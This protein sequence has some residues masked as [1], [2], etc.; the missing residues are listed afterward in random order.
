M[1]NIAKTIGLF[2]GCALLTGCGSAAGGLNNYPTGAD[3][4]QRIEDQADE[5]EPEIAWPATMEEEIGDVSGERYNPL[6]E[7]PFINA[8]EENQS[9]FSMDSWS[10]SYSNLR[11]YINRGEKING[12]I[13]KT[14]ELINYFDY[15]YPRPTG[16]ED[17]ASTI[18]VADAPWNKDHKL[19]AMAVTTKEAEIDPEQGNNY[20][21]LIDIS[22]SMDTKD[23]LPLVKQSLGL[24]LD[25]LHPTDRVSVVTYAGGVSKVL[26]GQTADNKNYI[27]N[28]INSLTAGGGTY[29]E[30]GIEMAYEVAKKWFI[31]DGNNR[32]I[33]ATDG[34]FNIG[35]SGKD[36]LKKLI[37][38]KRQSGIYLTCLGYGM[39]NYNDIT[40]ETLAKYGN[41]G[42]YYINNLLEA[43]KV[44]VKDLNKTLFA[45]AKDAKCE[46]TFDK[47]TVQSY[48]LIGYE[49]KAISQQDFYDETKD[50]GEIG[51]GHTSV[52]CYELIL[53]DGADLTGGLCNLNIHYKDPKTDESKAYVCSFSYLEST[54]SEDYTFIT[55]L[56]EFSLA[57]RNSNY[58]GTSSYDHVIEVLEGLNAVKEDKFKAE[59]L[60]LVKLALQNKLVAEN[61]S[62]DPIAVYIIIEWRMFGLELEKGTVLTPELLNEKLGFKEGL[63]SYYLDEDFVSPLESLTLESAAYVYAKTPVEDVPSPAVS[64]A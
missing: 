59:F 23:R 29:G 64:E 19:L 62:V 2:L 42:Y 51:S 57:I 25:N 9:Y 43:E 37:E 14:D 11:R 40:M 39:Y 47:A 28:K 12:N 16:T 5:K 3:V 36:D 60:G 6:S 31:P 45:V 44:L 55:S 35:K 50:A 30:G 13:I 27:K 1:K 20:V 24:L 48:R 33:V 26:D 8:E 7:N 38:E 61:K 34:D 41:G 52:V 22:G 53:N 58:K 56:I 4:I 21:F 32:V 18:E 17:F 46:I 54:P 10:A 63:V 15:S 49:N